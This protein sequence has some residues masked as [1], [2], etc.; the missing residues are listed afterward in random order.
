M[1]VVSEKNAPAPETLS[2]GGSVAGA[3]PRPLR[4][5][6]L[7]F[8]L[9]SHSALL[10]SLAGSMTLFAAAPASAIPKFRTS[11]I[12]GRGFEI[13]LCDL[14]GDH[15][16]DMV[17]LEQTNLAVFYQ[18]KN[19]GFNK[20]PDQRYELGNQPALVWAARLG[21]SAESLLLMTSEGVSELR[22]TN[23]ACP[24]ILDPIVRQPTVIPATL[25]DSATPVMHFPLSVK[26]GTSWPLLLVP[27]EGGL[28]VWQHHDAWQLAQTLE[29]ALDTRLW[30]LLGPH[31][32]YTK[33]LGL[34][35]GVADL[36][37]DGRE[38]LIVRRPNPSGTNTYAVYLQDTNGLFSAEPT[39]TC[40]EKSDWHSWLCWADLNGDGK[41]DL[42]KSTWLNE[43]WFVAGIRSGKVLVRI[44]FADEHG[45]L[46]AE[47]Q[48]VLRKSDWTAALP[49]LDIDGDGFPD[50]VLGYSLFD[51]REGARKMVTAKQLDFRLKFHFFRP[52]IG[53]AQEPDCQRDL[54]IHL[55]K[56]SL[57]MSSDRRDSFERFV[58]L[59]G[60][61]NGDGKRDLLVRDRSDQVSVYFF[62][63]R[64]EGFSRAP[65][66]R[67]NCPEPIDW[68]ETDDLNGDGVSDLII[69]L[70]KRNTFR[71][72][73][74]GASSG[75][76][77]EP[78]AK[79]ARDG[80]GPG[81]GN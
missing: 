30:P 51:T 45:Q 48:Q 22:F 13:I 19:L 8:A 6:A 18:D 5:R 36:N 62:V 14:D 23:R 54:V 42:I 43:P 9:V 33:N 29:R 78:H 74:S 39:V 77:N 24:P 75:P 3:H 41:V 68:L 27:T 60:D 15:L 1:T 16:Q 38:D 17:L 50:L 44:F 64:E 26:T 81:T 46:P 40:D 20:D 76:G 11:D 58:N 12:E 4:L 52:G 56:H 31:P 73:L 80:R 69:K 71:V 65:D 61:F 63:S 72:F 32:G 70:Q 79:D 67:F 55:D 47:P 37:G 35:L 10:L 53:F 21:S 49:V 59:R 66:L 34:S 7:L 2:P 25:D 28:Q 57:Q